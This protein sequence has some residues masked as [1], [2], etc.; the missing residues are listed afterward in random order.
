MVYGT[1]FLPVIWECILWSGLV[2]GGTLETEKAHCMR[3]HGP[4]GSPPPNHDLRLGL[5]TCGAGNSALPYIL[6]CQTL[7]LG[8]SKAEIRNLLPIYDQGELGVAYH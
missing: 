2:V 1:A 4:S 5:Q 8:P 6:I 3:V 7:N